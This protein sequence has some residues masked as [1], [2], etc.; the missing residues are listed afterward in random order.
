MRCIDNFKEEERLAKLLITLSITKYYE[1][2]SNPYNS[3]LKLDHH[4]SR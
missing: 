4:R 1:Q 3:L 2:D